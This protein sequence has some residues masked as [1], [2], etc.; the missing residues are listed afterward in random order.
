MFIAL[1]IQ[2]AMRMCHIVI[3]GLSGPTMFFSTL[4]HKSHDFRVGGNVPGYKMCV[5][6]F[7]SIILSEIFLTL[8][9]ITRDDIINV[10]KFSCIFVRFW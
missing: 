7:S 10:R 6:I 5:L 9:R 2:H 4:F 8:K 1:G 3:C